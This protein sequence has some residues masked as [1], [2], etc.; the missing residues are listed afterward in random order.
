M[1]PTDEEHGVRFI[2]ILSLNDKIGFVHSPLS[3]LQ[4]RNGNVSVK[5][6]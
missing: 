2:N 6:F 1:T 3:A 4:H 5:L